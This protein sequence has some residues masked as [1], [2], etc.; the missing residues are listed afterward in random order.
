MK[1][2]IALS[3]AAFL[4]VL[5]ASL[6]LAGNPFRTTISVVNSNGVYTV[7]GVNN[8]LFYTQQPVAFTFPRPATTNATTYTANYVVG[9]VT[10]TIGTKTVTA[11]DSTL[12]ATN[13]PPLMTGDKIV[14]TSTESGTNLTY[15]TG[16]EQ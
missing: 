16:L 7:A 5:S 1:K 12:L 10:N 6:V 15:Y 13:V 14:I 9:T 2:K 8:S 4:V 3:L 11:G